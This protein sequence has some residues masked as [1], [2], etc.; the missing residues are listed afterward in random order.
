M[1]ANLNN[2]AEEHAFTLP[3]E[4]HYRLHRPARPPEL[5]FLVLHGYGMNAQTMLQL[6]LL[7]LGQD[8]LVASI[9]APHQF[10]LGENKPNARIGYNWGTRNHGDAAIAFHHQMVSAVR[11]DLEARFQ[12]PAI[13]TILMGFS[14]P[15]G[16]NY[17]FAANH[18]DE[19]GGV[20]G[21][22][23]GVPKD[24]ATGSYGQVRAPLLHIAR[25]EDEFF[26]E[27]VTL[28]Y[29]A[30]LRTRAS[31]VEFHMLTGGHRFPSNGFSVIEPW[32][33]RVFGITR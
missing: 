9:Q 2:F 16:Y 28:D 14:Q 29:P 4:C 12:I 20:I 10:Y 30:R 27:E 32:L 24:F 33:K 6:T 17:R 8:R 5:L 19:I 3:F 18:P 25:S 26:P 13:R 31:D 1:N 23:G 15:V 21:I 7:M 22:C 11:R